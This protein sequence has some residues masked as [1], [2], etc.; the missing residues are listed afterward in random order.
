ME[1]GPAPPPGHGTHHYR[2][3][4]YALDA[5]LDLEPGLDKATLLDAMDGSSYSSAHA[6][7]HPLLDRF[8]KQFG[9][10]DM[11]LVDFNSEVI[12]YSVFKEVDF[13]TS[14]ISGPYRDSNLARVV[15]AVKR[16]PDLST[17]KVVDFEPYI[18]SHYAPEAFI[19]SP[20]FDGTRPIGILVL[21]FP[22][23]KMNEIMSWNYEWEKSGLGRKSDPVTIRPD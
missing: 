4:L 23:D 7:F 20:I 16:D 1:S 14:L 22:I 9:Y 8:R 10:H 18:P 13:G 5:E 6:K 15:E 17:A 19:A 21:E 3:T 11:L 2:F 12:V